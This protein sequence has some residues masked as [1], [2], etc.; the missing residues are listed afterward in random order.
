MRYKS[1]LKCF[2]QLVRVS[3]KSKFELNGSRNLPHQHGPDPQPHDEEAAKSVE[4]VGLAFELSAVGVDDG[5]RND[6]NKAVEGMKLW[7][8]ELVAVDHDDAQD[9]LDEHRGLGEGD[10]PPKTPC[11]EGLNLVGG[12]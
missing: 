5:D 7:E 1:N 10:I 6:A 11:P 8:F 3:D 2:V 12:Q 4:Q 9:H